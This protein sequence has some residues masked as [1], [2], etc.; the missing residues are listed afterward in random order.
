MNVVNCGVTEEYDRFISLSDFT[1][2]RLKMIEETAYPSLFNKVNLMGWKN[3]WL[4][5]AVAGTDSAWPNE[6][7][8]LSFETFAGSR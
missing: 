7:W 6:V 3:G 4:L 2:G 1:I 5:F 8:L